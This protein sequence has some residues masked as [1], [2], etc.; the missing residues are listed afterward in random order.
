MEGLFLVLL[1]MA[2]G[3]ALLPHLQWLVAQVRKR[4][5]ELDELDQTKG[6]GPRP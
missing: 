6:P 3:M 1:G 4:L 5:A 2:L